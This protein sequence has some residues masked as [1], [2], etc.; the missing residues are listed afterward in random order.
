MKA[1]FTVRPEPLP[2]GTPPKPTT[3]I[4]KTKSITAL[5]V[6][7]LAIAFATSASA[8]PPGKGTSGTSAKNSGASKVERKIEHKSMKRVGPPGKGSACTR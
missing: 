5:L 1:A 4:M 7:G 6:T 3:H 2:M 8:S